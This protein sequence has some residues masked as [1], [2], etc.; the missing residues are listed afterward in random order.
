MVWWLT[1]LLRSKVD[2]VNSKSLR[3]IHWALMIQANLNKK[4]FPLKT[5]PPLLI[6]LI[7]CAAGLKQLIGRWCQNS[8]YFVGFLN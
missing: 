6:V 8:N 4:S 7:G 5:H 1:G 3:I 2:F